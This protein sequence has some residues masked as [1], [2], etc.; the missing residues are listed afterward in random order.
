MLD[1][2]ISSNFEELIVFVCI[3]HAL[4]KGMAM[5]DEEEGQD[6]GRT[7]VCT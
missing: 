6:L 2:G 4:W 3:M 1:L 7:Q 5:E